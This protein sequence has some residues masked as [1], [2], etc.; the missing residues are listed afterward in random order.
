MRS[1]KVW[2]VHFNNH[3]HIVAAPSRKKAAEILG[4]SQRFM[5]DY[6]CA[7]GNAKEIALAMS[8]PGVIFH[9]HS[10]DYTGPY[11]EGKSR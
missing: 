9:R 1:L 8:R 2:G 5:A 7:T 11:V 4:V 6:G 3:R 10:N